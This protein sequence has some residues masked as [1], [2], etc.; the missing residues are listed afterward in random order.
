MNTSAALGTATQQAAP[1]P[2]GACN[3]CQRT[4]LPIL[5][6]RAAYA[7]AP[8]GTHMQPVSRGS[9]LMAVRMRIDQPRTLRQGYLYVLLDKTEW[10]AYQV[11]PEGALRQFRP[12]QPPREEPQPLSEDCIKQDHDVTASFINIDTAKYSTASIAF[13][14]DPWPK[15]VL[16]RYL[17]GKGEDGTALEPRFHQLDLKAARENP[18]SV[19]L[20]MT[21]QALQV[22]QKV[23]EYATPTAGDFSSAHGFSTRNHRLEALRGFVRIQR[24]RQQLPEGVLALVLLDPIGLVQEINH[25]RLAWQRQRQQYESDPT[26]NYKFF[27]SECLKRLREMCKQAA[28]DVVPASTNIVWE[29]QPSESGG[30]PVFHD[31]ARERAFLVARKTKELLGRLDDRYSE[32]KRAAFEKE[33]ETTKQ[34]LQQQIDDMAVLYASHVL[35]NP[36]FHL[37]ERYDYDAHV[38]Y[39]VVCYIQTLE[40]CLRGGI[41]EAS[42]PP[43]ADG[44][45]KPVAGPSAA[46]WEGWIKDGQSI[47]FKTLLACDKSLMESLVPTFNNQG[48]LDW[49]DFEKIYSP[50]TKIMASSDLGDKLIQPKVQAAIASVLAAY[51]GAVSRLGTQVN[52]GAR[53]V[54]TRVNSAALLLYSHIHMTQVAVQMKLGD[55][56]KLMCEQIREDRNK[57]AAAIEQATGR[58]H[59]Q[60]RSVLMGGVLS[61]ALADPKLAAQVVEVVLWVEGK[62]SDLRQ[63]FGSVVQDAAQHAGEM[64]GEATR[65]TSATVNGLT[66]LAGTLEPGAR[67]VL[68]GLQMTAFQVTGLARSGLS[69]ARNAAT[70]ARGAVGSAELLV[71]VGG[72][73]LLSQGL[74]KSVETVDATFGAKHDEAVLAVYSASVG[75]LGGSIEAVGLMMQGGAEQAQKVLR[76]PPVGMGAVS[77]LAVA[78]AAIA[79]F[80]GVIGAVAGVVDALASFKAAGRAG[81]EGGGIAKALY[82]GAGFA[83]AFSAG[84][85]LYALYATSTTILSASWILGP[86]GWAILLGMAAYVAWKI[87]E[88]AESSPLERWAYCSYFGRAENSM[89]AD[90]NTPVAA[91]NAAVLGVDV[92]AKFES[93]LVSKTFEVGALMGGTRIA[94]VP[95]PYLKYQ[96]SLPQYDASRAG[97]TWKL[98]VKRYSGE[99]LLASGSHRSTLSSPSAELKPPTRLDYEPHS[100]T[101]VSQERTISAVDGRK[102]NFLIVEGKIELMLGHDIDEAIISVEYLPDIHDAEMVAKMEVVEVI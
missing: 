63:R 70:I 46:A 20:A 67:K 51:N 96:I 64:L 90:A 79:R 38:A 36:L 8:Y 31:P 81:A 10:Q 59:K 102:T 26:T 71:A 98:L 56:Y 3:A 41:T 2:S 66:V 25:Q 21:E 89:F 47:V 57:L 85:T 27:T 68:A 30:P 99:E 15:S 95:I 82:I 83:Y 80:G 14:S 32:R 42:L 17:S 37:A 74:R 87:A 55:L 50:V 13:S 4:G 33:F 5:P 12:Y 16:D 60:V 84:F 1:N 94:V 24:Q 92:N 72:T 53:N 54:A 52:N 48:E 39:S 18:A 73:Y 49:S 78:G 91:L 61:L 23:L 97:Y 101:P 86:I 43:D 100:A 62:A 19:G 88:K 7:P 9:D 75:V 45:I 34:R 69:G 76:L 77:R 44:T 65:R 29:M 58:A 93:E 6:L 35:T 28:D 22:D 11:T 40:S